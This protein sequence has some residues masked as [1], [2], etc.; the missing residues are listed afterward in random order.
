MTLVFYQN[1]VSADFRCSAI[2][3]DSDG[4]RMRSP[5]ALQL[6]LLLR[7]PVFGEKVVKTPP[8][9]APAA[10]NVRLVTDDHV[11]PAPILDINR[12]AL[13]PGLRLTR[14]QRDDLLRSMGAKELGAVKREPNSAR[15][16]FTEV[17]AGHFGFWYESHQLIGFQTDKAD[18]V[19][20]RPEEPAAWKRVDAKLGPHKAPHLCFP[21]LVQLNV[22]GGL[23]HP[24]NQPLL[25]PF[26]AQAR[27]IASH[28]FVS[29]GWLRAPKTFQLAFQALL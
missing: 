1:L 17:E 5:L 16:E 2:D 10:K 13:Q 9:Q 20:S 22:W 3:G 12:F 26:F 21:L 7:S 25:G 19:L 11:P 15:S 4:H 27:R 28:P 8:R 18:S 23:W 6:L 29:K 14:S 24:P